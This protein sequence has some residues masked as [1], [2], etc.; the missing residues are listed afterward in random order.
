[1][2][3][4]LVTLIMFGCMFFCIFFGF[5]IVWVM[6]G[7]AG[8]SAFF[9]WGP[10]AVKIAAMAVYP[11]WS[12]NLLLAVPMFILMA[13]LLQRSDVADDLYEMM[14]KWF[15]RSNGGLAMGTVFICTMFAAI[16][17]GGVGLITMTMIALPAM[18]NRKYDKNIVLGSI[19]TGS[20]LGILIPPSIILILFAFV[21]RE[22]IGRLWFAGFGPGL[23]MAFL[24]V[25]YIGIRTYLN[26]KLGPALPKE[27][28]PSWKEKIATL[29]KVVPIMSVIILMMGTIYSGFCTP[30]EASVIGVLGV[31][32][33]I[34]FV[35]G[36]KKCWKI[37]KD[38]MMPTLALNGM[39]F[40]ILLGIN[41]FNSIY[42]ALGA[43]RLIG[44]F[45]LSMNVSPLTVIAVMMVFILIMG[46]MMDDYAILLICAPI[47]VPIVKDLG[48]DPIWYGILFIMNI[49]IAFC[50][51]PYGFSLFLMRKLLPPDLTMMD[52][53][54][55]V[56]PFVCIQVVT[57]ILVMLFPQIALWLPDQMM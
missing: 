16:S 7:V 36:R 33:V 11:N 29:H 9:L 17:T 30:T 5:P 2:N 57:L 48:F 6:G 13:N 40:W 53:Y 4:L 51:P 52:M 42:V 56:W 12:S 49:Q 50:T 10:G 27:E 19:I 25:I 54:R 39:V 22:S 15:G 35:H 21:S 31:L 26:P 18:M 37:I 43:K 38:S 34:T 8:I 55:S 28:T 20:S 24:F 14:H 45:I 3:I 32:V 23:L 44:G 47:F 1:M 41:F 46:M